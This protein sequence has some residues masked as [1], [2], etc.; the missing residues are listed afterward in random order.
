MAPPLASQPSSW[1]GVSSGWN[2]TPSERPTTNACDATGVRASSRA[3]G[4]SRHRSWCHWNHGPGGTS[5]ASCVAIS[6]QPSSTAGARST[7]PPSAA[8]SA[9]PP[10]QMPSTGTP[11]ATAVRSIASSGPTHEAMSV[12]PTDQAAPIGTTTSKE[13]GSGNLAST[14]GSAKRSAGTTRNSSTSYPRSA[15]ASPTGPGGDT[16]S[17][18]TTRARMRRSAHQVLDGVLVLAAPSDGSEDDAEHEHRERQEHEHPPGEV[19]TPGLGRRVDAVGDGAREQ[20]EARHEQVQP[21][22]Q[23]DAGQR[24]GQ[25]RVPDPPVVPRPPEERDDGDAD[26]RLDHDDRHDG[27]PA[28]PVEQVEYRVE[29]AG[30]EEH[31]HGERDHRRGDRRDDRSARPVGAV[32]P[33]GQH[34]GTA[35]REEVARRGVLERQEPGEEAGGD[36]PAHEGREPRAHVALG[37]REDDGRGVGERRP[38]HGRDRGGLVDD[39]VR[40]QARDDREARQC[41]EHGDR[42]HR[43]VRR[44]RDGPLR[45]P[46]LLPVDGRRLEADERR[47]REGQRDP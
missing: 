9:W 28:E 45:V 19:E 25:E 41:E 10:K 37:H 14:P 23:T 33:A 7:S 29:P 44:A 40:T 30:G 24:R 5:S 39:L 26:E 1:P 13:A 4:G 47:E 17:C 8:A 43:Q 42:A 2:W 6:T 46:G 15:N 38:V 12:A 22:Q 3:P 31:D 35:H 20:P 11:A 16:W 32:E 18:W 34:T 36:E 27:E 21:G